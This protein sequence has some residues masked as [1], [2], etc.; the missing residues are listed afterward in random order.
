MAPNRERLPNRRFAETFQFICDQLPY[1]C[2]N[3][4]FADGRI[5]EIF[6]TSGK[7]GSDADT[8]A[9]DAAIACSFALQHGCTVEEIGHA[10]CRDANSKAMGPLGLA[11]DLLSDQ[12][13]SPR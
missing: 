10:L 6:L 11:L 7:S 3:G 13:T 12:T 9:R 4:K 1:T 5:G 8:S 2:T